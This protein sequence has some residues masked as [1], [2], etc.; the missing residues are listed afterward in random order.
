MT[1]T[2]RNVRIHIIRAIVIPFR[3]EIAQ[4][5]YRVVIR[6]FLKSGERELG[7]LCMGRCSHFD[8]R[9][10]KVATPFAAKSE[11]MER[12]VRIQIDSLLEFLCFSIQLDE[13]RHSRL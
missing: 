2:A 10:I 3:R 11:A 5:L 8:R 13:T 9:C 7:A 6:R 4:A 1:T 12:F